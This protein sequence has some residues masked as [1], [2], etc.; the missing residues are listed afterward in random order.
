MHSNDSFPLCLHRHM[1]AKK[2]GFHEK[3]NWPV[4]ALGKCLGEFFLT[5]MD[6]VCHLVKAPLALLN[7]KHCLKPEL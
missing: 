1:H 4:W 7:S 5:R 6:R 2:I 3:K